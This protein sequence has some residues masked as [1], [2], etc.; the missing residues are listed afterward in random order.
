MTEKKARLPK[1][2][3][4]ALYEMMVLIRRT[5]LQVG[6]LFADGQIPGSVHLCIGQEAVPAGIMSALTPEDTITSTHRGHG[7]VIAKGTD[8]V[9]FFKE[10]MGRAG[11]VCGGRGG[12]MHVAD[13][14][15]GILGANG[16]VGG[17]ISIAL[18]NALAHRLRRTGRIAVAIFGDGARAE[19]IFHESL[20]I[21][22]LW[23]LPLLFVCENNKWAEFSPSSRHFGADLGKLAEAFGLEHAEVDGNDVAAVSKAAEAAV[24]SIRNGGGPFVLECVTLRLR[25]HYEGDPQKYRDPAELPGSEGS[26][27][28]ARAAEVMRSYPKGEAELSAIEERVALR[29]EDA[30]CQAK[31]DPPPDFQDALRGVYTAVR[32]E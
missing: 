11:G 27:P 9:G 15:V 13:M 21:S 8:L 25:G 32:G 6:K 22:S 26:D 2:R 10:I 31:D 19:G 24:A 18:G 3:F 12:S 17:G 29:V 23:G 28:I 30:V 16:I 4:A 14:S 20:N 7:H 5:E 1:D